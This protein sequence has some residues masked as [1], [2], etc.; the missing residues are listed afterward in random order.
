MIGAPAGRRHRAGSAPGAAG[1]TVL[2]W[3][4]AFI[5]IRSAG[6]AYSPGAPALGRLLAGALVPGLVALVRRE[7]LPPRA[8]WPGMACSK[9]LWF[10]GYMVVLNRG[11]REVDA[12]TAAMVVNVGPLPI[13]LLSGPLLGER[14]PRLPAAGMAV[15]FAGAVVVGLST[16]GRRRGPRPGA[17]AV[18]AGRRLVRGRDGRAEARVAPR[19]RPAPPCPAVSSA[20]C[21]AC[22]SAGRRPRGRAG[23]RAH[24][25]AARRPA[26]RGSEQAA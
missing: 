13:A 7:G 17:A 4:S 20:P 25:S 8:D 14:I 26:A 5:A 11:E 10:G 18:P 22:P 3:A 6:Y 24:G 15:A 12:G 23:A 16:P 9:V 1:V 2:L 19:I 21:A